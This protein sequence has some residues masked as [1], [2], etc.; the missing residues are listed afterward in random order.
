MSFVGAYLKLGAGKIIFFYVTALEMVRNFQ[1][2]SRK[3]M[4]G[5]LV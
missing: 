1:L 4:S 3:A 2:T 5:M